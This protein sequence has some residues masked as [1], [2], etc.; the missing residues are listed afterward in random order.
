MRWI[1]SNVGFAVCMVDLLKV[2]QPHT[3][4]KWSQAFFTRKTSIKIPV[5][6]ELWQAWRCKEQ[7]NLRK[8][9]KIF[10]VGKG[11]HAETKRQRW[12]TSLWWPCSEAPRSTS[13]Y[14]RLC[15][16]LFVKFY[17][18]TSFRGTSFLMTSNSG[19]IQ[20]WWR[21]HLINY[22]FL[23]FFVCFLVYLSILLPL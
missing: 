19:V 8:I 20:K 12:A 11:R 18:L 1:Y 23:H 13:F 9:F 21:M 15:S 22:L 14:L 5:F 2:F 10:T 7:N 6:P 17:L 3:L 4:A 16:T